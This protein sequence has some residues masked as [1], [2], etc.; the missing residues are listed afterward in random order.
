MA[1]PPG[2]EPGNDGIKT[3]CL[4]AW[5]R[6]NYLCP[7]PW[8]GRTVHAV[9]QRATTV[10]RPV[11]RL[12]PSGSAPGDGLAGRLNSTHPA[13]SASPSGSCAHSHPA[14]CAFPPDS[15]LLSSP[16]ERQQ[17]PANPIRRRSRLHLYAAKRPSKEERL[18]PFATKPGHTARA[19]ARRAAPASGK[20][21]KTH[22]PVPVKRAVEKRPRKSSA[23]PI[24]G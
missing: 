8:P 15:S 21:A 23:S 2:F 22:A 14:N 4:T 3:R 24:T 6:P 12:A 17:Q 11:L 19:N 20:A 18:V 1:G 16:P 13:R 5:R 7:T 10:T 9:A